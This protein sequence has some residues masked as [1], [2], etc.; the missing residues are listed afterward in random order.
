[1]WTLHSTKEQ[2]NMY[3]HP[4]QQ[5]NRHDYANNIA[6]YVNEDDS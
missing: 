6:M 2:Y 5:A 1:M 4:L 3:K